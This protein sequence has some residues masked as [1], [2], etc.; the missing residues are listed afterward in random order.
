MHFAVHIPM[1]VSGRPF[2]A[3]VPYFIFEQDN[4]EMRFIAWSRLGA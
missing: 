2:A 1:D 3:A 4:I